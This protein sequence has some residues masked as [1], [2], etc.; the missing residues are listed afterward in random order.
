MI[1]LRN[2]EATLEDRRR[3]LNAW[4]AKNC[5]RCLR[6]ADCGIHAD[7]LADFFGPFERAWELPLVSRECYMKVE[8]ASCP[9]AES[10]V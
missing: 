2:H 8:R 3:A 5:N 1:T 4:L 7:V 10:D 9:T 6:R